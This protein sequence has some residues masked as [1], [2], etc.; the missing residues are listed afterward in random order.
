[1]CGKYVGQALVKQIKNNIYS[2]NKNEADITNVMNQLATNFIFDEIW[3]DFHIITI[4]IIIGI[5]PY[6]YNSKSNIFKSFVLGK[7]PLT[8]I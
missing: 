4:P 8:C 7:L 1:M 6:I 2:A 5:I 3:I